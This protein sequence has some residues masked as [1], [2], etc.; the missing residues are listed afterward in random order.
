MFSIILQ[1]ICSL[2]GYEFAQKKRAVKLMDE[3]YKF[4]S[5]PTPQEMD[6]VTSTLTDLC[7]S[8]SFGSSAGSNAD[9]S[10]RSSDNEPAD[11]KSPNSDSSKCQKK[12]GTSEEK[13]IH[14]VLKGS[15]LSDDEGPSRKQPK[16]TI[17]K[18]QQQEKLDQSNERFEKE[19]SPEKEI[20][21]EDQCRR[22]ASRGEEISQDVPP[23]VDLSRTSFSSEPAACEDEEALNM[24]KTIEISNLPTDIQEENLRMIL[25]NRRYIGKANAHIEELRLDIGNVRASITYTESGGM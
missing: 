13:Q 4:S 2:S 10:M 12:P 16:L 17:S 23:S 5:S 19:N 25:E 7:E 9:V 20:D 22:A 11:S 14:P 21:E 15:S 1:N 8:S 6:D 18:Y 24:T 3:V